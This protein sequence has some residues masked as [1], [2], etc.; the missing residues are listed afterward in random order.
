MYRSMRTLPNGAAAGQGKK[1]MVF[2][3]PLISSPPQL[4]VCRD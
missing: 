4:S 3:K 2:S 1:F